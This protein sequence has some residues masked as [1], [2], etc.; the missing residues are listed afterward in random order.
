MREIRLS[1]SEGGVGPRPHPD[2]YPYPVTSRFRF[3]SRTAK[4]HP[5]TPLL[6]HGGKKGSM[7]PPNKK[8]EHARRKDRVPERLQLSPLRSTSKVERGGRVLFLRRSIQE[9]RHD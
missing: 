3:K 2:P 9:V 4:N 6:P 7:T 1:G 8:V 5:T